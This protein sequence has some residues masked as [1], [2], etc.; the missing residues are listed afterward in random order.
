MQYV[1]IFNE[2]AQTILTGGSNL[3]ISTLDARILDGLGVTIVGIYSQMSGSTPYFQI[4]LSAPATTAGRIVYRLNGIDN[5][6]PV[7]Y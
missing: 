7:R 3:N 4:N 2:H 5:F 1:Q 6:K